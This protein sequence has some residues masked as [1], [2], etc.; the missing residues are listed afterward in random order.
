MKYAYLLPFLFIL[1]LVSVAQIKPLFHLPDTIYLD[2]QNTVEST[3]LLT[4]STLHGF[5]VALEYDTKYIIPESIGVKLL[6]NDSTVRRGEYFELPYNDLQ[7]GAFTYAATATNKGVS[8]ADET[9]AFSLRFSFA[10]D[11]STYLKYFPNQYY[12]LTVTLW[13]MDGMDTQGQW[14]NMPSIEKTYYIMMSAKD[15]A[16]MKADNAFID[17]W[18]NPSSDQ[19][20]FGFSETLPLGIF[21]VLKVYDANVDLMEKKVVVEEGQI[22]LDI[23]VYP[24][25]WYVVVLFADERNKEWTKFLEEPLVKKT[26][27]KK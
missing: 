19:I 14:L 4:D 10:D 9:P 7:S 22:T 1:S 17:A 24:P 8:L 18:P 5:Y 21:N 11:L 6:S 3:F 26:F 27:L 13:G 23:S 15:E 16:E 20:T 12:P 25:G 2:E